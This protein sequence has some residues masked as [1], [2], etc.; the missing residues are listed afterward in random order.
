MIQPGRRIFNLYSYRK[1][2]P[3]PANHCI[4]N[5]QH[6]PIVLSNNGYFFIIRNDLCHTPIS[7]AK[8]QYLVFFV[9]LRY[10]LF[11]LK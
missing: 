2:I 9:N 11:C 4:N 1:N 6:F 8:I 7:N 3:A 5:T 10:E